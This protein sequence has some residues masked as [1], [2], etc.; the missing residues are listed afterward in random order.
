MREDHR[1]PRPTFRRAN[2]RPTT[3]RS[4]RRNGRLHVVILILLACAAQ[5]AVA[6][7]E[8]SGEETAVGASTEAATLVEGPAAIPSVE[9]EQRSSPP[10]GAII[11][12]NDGAGWGPAAARTILAGHI[13]WDRVE[14]GGTSS[15]AA[16]RA[17]GF[18]VLAIAGNTDDG[19]PL[20]Q[21]NPV[22]WGQG[23][24]S[25]LRSNPG[26]AIAEAANEAYLK[27][28]VADPAQYGRMYIAAVRDLQAAGIRT[29]LLFNMTG[30]YP[31]GSWSAPTGWSQDSSG[32]G[33]LR[34]AVRAVPGL[35]GAILANGISIHPYGALGENHHDDY[36][37]SAAAAD[38]SVAQAVL[39]AIPPFYITEFGY[40]LNA[41]GRDLGA[42]SERQQATK[43]KAAYD[44]LLDDPHLAGIWW[45]QSHDDSTG[46]F[47]YMTAS[48][49][50]RPSYATLASIA[51]GQGQ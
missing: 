39:G 17:D 44:V 38:E 6:A 19:T 48:G 13:A 28:G 25:E 16:S 3:W 26:A 50:T 24:V 9:G 11:G 42:C 41:C 32:G 31:R 23:V 20:S 18:D 15:V 51:G 14:I 45:Y 8:L 33:W 46:H 43:M 12:T 4:G 37:V 5:P 7:E 40:D 29:P 10:S 27:G 1:V 21:V 30:D 34:D 49:A 22:Q 35:A 2:G 36:G 47:G